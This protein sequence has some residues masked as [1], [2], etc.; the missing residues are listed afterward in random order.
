MR[1]RRSP[2]NQERLFT[3]LFKAPDAPKPAP[4]PLKTA[5]EIDAMW[6]IPKTSRSLMKRDAAKEG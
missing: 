1:T 3:A 4:A 5:A 2:R 6:W